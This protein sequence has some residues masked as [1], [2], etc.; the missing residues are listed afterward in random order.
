MRSRKPGANFLIK[1]VA[2]PSA[3]IRQRRLRFSIPRITI[4]ATCSGVIIFASSRGVS[5]WLEPSA[6]SAEKRTF[7]AVNP[8]QATIT[9][10]PFFRFSIRTVSRNPVIAY[11][12]AE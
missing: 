11:F 10:N 2:R 12:E 1:C 5:P 6:V 3:S 4:R 8:G 7:E 9:C